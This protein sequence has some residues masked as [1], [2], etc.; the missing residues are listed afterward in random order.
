[1]CSLLSLMQKKP[2][3]FHFIDAN[4][5]FVEM[6]EGELNQINVH[7]LWSEEKGYYNLYICYI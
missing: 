4:V 3:S 2:D 1:M 7:R 6:P 5:M